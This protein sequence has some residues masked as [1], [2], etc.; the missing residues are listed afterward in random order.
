MEVTP[1]IFAWLT[2]LNVINPFESFSRHSINDFLIPERAISA[3][4]GGKYMDLIIE[5]LQSAY[6]N[7]YNKEKNYI[8]ELK[9]LKQIPEGQEYIANNLKYNNWKIIFEVLAHFGLNFTE[10]DLSLII[11]N[12]IEQLKKIISKIYYLYTKLNKSNYSE[13]LD[14]M[15]DIN[16]IKYKRYRYSKKI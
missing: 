11:D 12:N 10:N 13:K 2:N 16:N 8:Y 3:L 15:F 5:P 14:L 1:E 9:K 6:N 7:F 4:F